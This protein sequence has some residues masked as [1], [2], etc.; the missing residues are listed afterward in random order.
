MTMH[1]PTA[2]GHPVHPAEHAMNRGIAGMVLFIASEIMLFGGLFAGYFFIRQQ[3]AEWPPAGID[4]PPSFGLALVLTA[5]LISS[6]VFAHFGILGIKRGNRNQLLFG[7]GV[8]LILGT[9]FIAGQTYEWLVLIDE[10]L[11]A[12]SG[13]YG[14]TF[15]VITGFHGAHVI[16]GLALLAVVFVRGYWRDFT[17]TRHVIAD[18]GVMYWHFVDFVWIFVLIILYPNPLSY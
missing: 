6:G 2:E 11:T 7:I 15:F 10:G 12:S 9:I 14:A 5:F 1:A 16:G 17:P 13:V 8:A 4:H 18:A 3:A